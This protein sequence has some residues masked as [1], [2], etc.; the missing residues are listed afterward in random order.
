[1]GFAHSSIDR[2]YHYRRYERRPLQPTLFDQ[3]RATSDDD[4]LST[5]DHDGEFGSTDDL[6][7]GASSLRSQRLLHR[8]LSSDDPIMV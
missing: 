1:M 4:L 8:Q 6:S 3:S 7:T 5:T 2:I